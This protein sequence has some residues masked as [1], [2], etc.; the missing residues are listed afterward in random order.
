MNGLISYGNGIHAVDA[1]YLRPRFA[2]VHVIEE[3]GRIAL[4]DTGTNHSLPWVLCALEQLGA[5]ADQVDH[6][7]LT[8]VH[9]DHAGGAGL[10]M[11]TFPNARLAVH[12]RGVRHMVDPSRL[13]AGAAAVYGEDEIRRLYGEVL[14]IDAG[15]I[16][17]AT[18]GLRIDLAGR[19]LRVLD[20][21]GHARH[22]VCFR[23][24]R[25]GHIFTGDALG[26]SYPEFDAGNKRFV[27]PGTTPVQFSPEDMHAS[28]DMLLGCDPGV[29]YLT[30]FGQVTGVARIV[31]DLHR[32]IDAYV[33]I[34]RRHRNA[35]SARHAGI[36]S[37]LADL[38][39]EEI[40][41][42]GC[43]LGRE[44]I[45]AL[46]TQDIEINAQGLEVWLDGEAA[47]G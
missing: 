6:V 41:A 39:V 44:Q 43:A 1:H 42:I 27:F 9:L 15:R 19:G 4:V 10:M 32:L 29:C 20:T 28:I 23:D 11:R 37:D 36:C 25:T 3:G 14:P 13:I 34:A 22:H 35:G 21:P 38:L 2:A 31:S 24:E 45:L 8:H 7:L 12:P 5:T 33:A 47:R 46:L 16:V 18:H 40:R 17:E 26:V 30:H